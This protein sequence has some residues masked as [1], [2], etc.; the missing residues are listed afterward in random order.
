M[1]VT[2]KLTSGWSINLEVG[3]YRKRVTRSAWLLCCGTSAAERGIDMSI[4]VTAASS[5]LGR[6]TVEALLARGVPA[7]GIVATSRDV[8]MIKDLADRGVVVRRADFAEPDGL[9]AAC[10]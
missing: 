7:S 3:S 1:S 6:L 4:V 8:R 9:P 2:S 5:H 10:E